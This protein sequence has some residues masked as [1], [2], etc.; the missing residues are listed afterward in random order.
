MPKEGYCCTC[1]KVTIGDYKEKEG[2]NNPTTMCDECDDE[3]ANYCCK[4]KTDLKKFDGR[5]V[6]CKPCLNIDNKKREIIDK[7]KDYIS[8]KEIAAIKKILG[9]TF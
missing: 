9:L 1:G 7:L 3:I 5:L 6:I 8:E 4:C 2:S